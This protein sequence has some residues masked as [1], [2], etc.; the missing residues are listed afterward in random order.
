[1]KRIN[2]L[3]LGCF[4]LLTS[5]NFDSGSNDTKVVDELLVTS[6]QEL[7]NLFDT[8]T[9]DVQVT[10]VGT[11]EKILADDTE[12]SQHQKFILKLPT[13]ETLL[14]VHNIDLAE[15]IDNLQEGDEIKVFGQYE[16]NDR[17]G[18]IHWTHHDPNRQHIGGWIEHKGKFYE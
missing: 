18:L 4:F 1:M 15:R 13:N 2:Y 7:Q 9:S 11:V 10:F 3:L 16:W 17:G 12:G 8:Q 6:S 5:C 14:I